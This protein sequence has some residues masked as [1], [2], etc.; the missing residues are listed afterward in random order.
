MANV[1]RLEQVFVNLLVNAAQAV[2]DGDPAS[3]EVVV[4]LFSEG[5]KVVVEVRD[6][7]TGIAPDALRRVFEPFFTTKPRGVGTG[8]GLPISRGIVTAFGGE[9]TAKSALGVGTTFRM[10][11]PAAPYAEAPAPSSDGVHPSSPVHPMVERARVLVVD[12]EPLV[13]DM[14]RRTLSEIHD[15]S[16]VTDAESALERIL[17]GDEFDVIFCDLLMPRMSG[18]DLYEELE[19]HRP[20]VQERIVFMTGGAFT[21][22]AAKFLATVP[23]PKLTK[24]FDLA[25]IERVVARMLRARKS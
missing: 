4:S 3:N 2:T 11:L 25:M 13:A 18:M 16:A 7:G 15:V 10:T 23:N 9:L 5:D 24:P 17:S 22:R 21:E 20:G 14:L 19:K 1:A 6:T 8:L 12:D